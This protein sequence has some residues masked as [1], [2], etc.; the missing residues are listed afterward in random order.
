MDDVLDWLADCGHVD[1]ENGE[2]GD[3]GDGK[4]AEERAAA[5]E[6]ASCQQRGCGGDLRET[7][8]RKRGSTEIV[9]RARKLA[10]SVPVPSALGTTKAE[11]CREAV[12]RRWEK[13]RAQHAEQQ[14]EA[15][16]LSDAI[17]PVSDEHKAL[18]F[19]PNFDVPA[20][21]VGV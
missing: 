13:V 1:R 3:V 11:K 20:L 4:A 17:V 18:S 2:A 8:G 19:I 5:A 12:L 15:P 14:G 21:F 10:A 16:V 7:R 9:C 6:D